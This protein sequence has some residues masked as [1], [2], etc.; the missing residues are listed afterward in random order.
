MAITSSAKKAI[1]ASARK[2]VFNVRRKTAI[3]SSMKAVKRLVSK[4]DISAAR[5]LL[6]QVYKALDKAKKT[7][8]LKKNTASRMKS[9]ITAL[10][11]KSAK[12]KK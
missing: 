11:E 7:K 2:R 5:E 8:F 4:G 1:R 12:N 3:E 9:R 6:P 10:I